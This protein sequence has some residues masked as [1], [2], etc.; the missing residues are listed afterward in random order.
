ML[1]ITT[2]A[3]AEAVFLNPVVGLKGSM[4]IVA[5]K[6][7]LKGNRKFNRIQVEVLL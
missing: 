5:C 6:S 4:K 3:N 7:S 2:R 1:L